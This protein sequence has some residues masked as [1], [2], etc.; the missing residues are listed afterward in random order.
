[1]SNAELIEQADDLRGDDSEVFNMMHKLKDA[2]EE[3]ERQRRLFSQTNAE[4]LTENG[5]LRG[6]LAAAQAVIAEALKQT[7]RGN[8]MTPPWVIEALCQSPADA[9]P[10]AKAA[11]WDEGARHVYAEG[12]KCSFARD[13][14]PCPY[15]P[16]RKDKTDE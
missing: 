11:A 15:N 5:V 6:Q 10:A 9:L 2:L 12:G 8:L 4:T 7:R 3:S 14:D 13:G 16:Y 1:M